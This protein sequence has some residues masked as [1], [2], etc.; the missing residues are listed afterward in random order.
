MPDRERGAL[1]VT[2]NFP[3]LRGGMERLNQRMLEGLASTMPVALVGPRGSREF[4]PAEAVVDEV[5]GAPLWKFIPAAMI[6]GLRQAFRGRPGVVLA[7]SGLTA[8]LAW[9][10]ARAIGARC[11]V[12]LHGLDIV[13]SNRVYHWCWLP[14]IRRCDLA[15]AN[16]RNTARLA[17]AH[18]IEERR[19]S[20]VNPG[21]DL[22]PPDPA[23]RRRFRSQHQLDE[24]PLLL[25]VGR[26]TPR[27]G[28]VRF[29]SEVLPTV[30]AVRPDAV[31]VIIGADASDAL[32]RNRHSEHARIVESARA[33]GVGH[34]LRWL[35][36]CDDVTLSAAY[37]A[38]DVHVFPLL[39]MPGDI[40]GFGMVAI[41]AAA[42]GLPTVAYAVGGVGDAVAEGITGSLCAAGDTAAFGAE[43]VRW[44]S[45]SAED[46]RQCERHAAR[47]AW[48]RF[49]AEL[50]AALD[51]AVV[52]P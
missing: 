9:L 36:H 42:H 35:P 25:A 28:L 47:F 40:E 34:A 44:L 39:E 50:Q 38:A 4:A 45:A 10:A 8:P 26:L 19:I 7:G 46:R 12:Y 18:G 51:A 49:D 3:P 6:A 2:R 41:E 37:R 21:T 16:S 33:A 48:D 15:I 20:V 13:V 27:K 23:A 11:A 5:P 43:V 1:L 52:A 22:P 32:V 24:V 30:L 17:V 14:A 31:F 29:V